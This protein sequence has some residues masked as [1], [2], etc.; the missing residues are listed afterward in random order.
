MKAAADAHFFIRPRAPAVQIHSGGARLQGER[1]TNCAERFRM[2]R[3]LRKKLIY[4]KIIIHPFDT[5]AHTPLETRLKVDALFHLFRIPF[6][7]AAAEIP[8]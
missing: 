2:G 4:W 8:R 7:G 3:K 6:Q 1:E 5:H